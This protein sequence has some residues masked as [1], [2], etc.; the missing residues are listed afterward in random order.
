M[1]YQ[2]KLENI[3]LWKLEN[4]TIDIRNALGNNKTTNTPLRQYYKLGELVT[5]PGADICANVDISLVS[6]KP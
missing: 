1:R 5:E 6:I 4:P 2:L 3:T